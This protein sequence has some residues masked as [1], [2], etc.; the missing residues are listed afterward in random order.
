VSKAF[1]VTIM[2][3]PP[4]LFGGPEAAVSGLGW[5]ESDLDASWVVD[6]TEL[7][8]FVEGPL[9]SDLQSWFTSAGAS[10]VVEQRCDVYRIDDRHDVGVKLRSRETL[11]VKIRRSRGPRLTLDNG[12]HGVL[13][14][15]RKWTFGEQLTRRQEHQPSVEVAKSIVKRR[16]S[17]AGHEI[18]LPGDAYATTEAVCDVEVARVVV[19]EIEA[20]TF[21]FAACGPASTHASS[22]VASWRSLCSSGQ[23]PDELSVLRGS[24][25]Y[26][27]WLKRRV[28]PS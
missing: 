18:A 1:V 8:W 23:H 16:F 13:E 14:V 9:P 5:E 4:H 22:I 21:A 28:P 11:E 24:I 3:H 10:G 20:W 7:R 26:S 12:P 15:W 17:T 19:G 25:G 6:T 2:E 27:E